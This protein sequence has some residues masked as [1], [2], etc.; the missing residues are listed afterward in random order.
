VPVAKVGRR[1]HCSARRGAAFAVVGALALV[2][3]CSLVITTSDLHPGPEDSGTAL[4]DALAEAGAVDP[5]RDAEILPEWL[6]ASYDVNPS[7]VIVNCADG[8]RDLQGDPNNCGA[9][10]HKCYETACTNGL[11]GDSRFIAGTGVTGLIGRDDGF[12]YFSN[13]AQLER[14]PADGGVAEII[15]DPAGGSNYYTVAGQV[16]A[17][18]IAIGTLGGLELFDIASRV[19]KVPSSSPTVAVEGIS[20][21][22]VFW[23]DWQGHAVYRTARD[24]SGTFITVWSGGLGPGTM[25]ADDRQVF[26][27]TWLNLPDSSSTLYAFEVDSGTNVIRLPPQQVRALFLDPTYI[28]WSDVASGLIYRAARD[29][30]ENA[31]PIAIL[32]P[33]YGVLTQINGVV[34][35]RALY[36]GVSS[37]LGYGIMTIPKCGGRARM[38]YRDNVGFQQNLV[39]DDEFIYFG[40]LHEPGGI[41][42]T[43]K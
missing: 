19:T 12:F 17:G 13:G 38:L 35:D 9:C 6:D 21:P 30:P 10:G 15:R 34:D 22:D 39:V 36:F 3:G 40:R 29:A 25:V 26:W 1:R 33:Q 32:P 11:C 14:G 20:G 16:R 5:C 4:S 23:G 2:G 42:R 37:G 31:T 7:T 43:A 18:T 27:A 28:F 8:T 24:G 41:Y